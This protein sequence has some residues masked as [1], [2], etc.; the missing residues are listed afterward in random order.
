M[1]TIYKERANRRWEYWT[2]IDGVRYQLT[3][4]AALSDVRRGLSKLLLVKDF[5]KFG[6]PP[7]PTKRNA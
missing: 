3:E 7:A 2:Y 4:K 1:D 5:P 6:Y